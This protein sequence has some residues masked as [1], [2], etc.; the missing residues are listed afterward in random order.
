MSVYQVQK[1]LFNLHNDLELKQ[2]Y[3]ESPQEVLKKYDLGDAELKALLEPDVGSLY[4]MGIHTY[5]LWAYGALMGVKPDV[6]F[7]QIGRDKN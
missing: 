4:R 1:L 5:L 3:K 2:K 7:K 6:Y